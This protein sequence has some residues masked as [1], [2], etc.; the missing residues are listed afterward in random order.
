M[1]KAYFDASGKNDPA[2]RI[3]TL[4]GLVASEAVWPD[5]EKE[6]QAVLGLYCLDSFHM[7]DAIASQRDFKG[8]PTQKV[9]ALVAQLW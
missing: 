3:L 5:F 1:L 8:W 7:M 2:T 9:D 4:G 6:W